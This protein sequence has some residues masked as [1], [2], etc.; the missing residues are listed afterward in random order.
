MVIDCSYRTSGSKYEQVHYRRIE[1]KCWLYLVMLK[2][3]EWNRAQ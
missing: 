3:R 1:K 2:Y